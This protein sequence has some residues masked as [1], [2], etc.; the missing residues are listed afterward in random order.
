M[1]KKRTSIKSI[2]YE[3]YK[4]NKRK[5]IFNQGCTSHYF[6]KTYFSKYDILIKNIKKIR[7]NMMT[8]EDL[9]HEIYALSK[10]HHEH[11]DDRFNFAKEKYGVRYLEYLKSNFCKNA[12]YQFGVNIFPLTQRMIIPIYHQ[13]HLVGLSGRITSQHG[14]KKERTKYYFV[15]KEK[16]KYLFAHKNFQPKDNIVVTE[17]YVDTMR[18]D[19][20][21][22]KSVVSIMG[23][24]ISYEQIE[25]L[26]QFGLPVYFALDGDMAGI[27]GTLQLPIHKFNVPVFVYPLYADYDPDELLLDG[28][29]LPEPIPYAKWFV[30]TLAHLLKYNKMSKKEYYHQLVISDYFDEYR[31]T[32]N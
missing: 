17:G 25:Q 32:L 9:L 22:G 5:K 2:F 7:V 24:K 20:A 6:Y 8:F 26:N 10:D 15:I 14:Q 30:Q 3:P 1:I 13:G 11:F 18:I 28:F 29:V 23:S 4:D 31:K 19:I 12:L 27:K 21:T 16:S